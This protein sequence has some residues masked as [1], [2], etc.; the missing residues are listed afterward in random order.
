MEP[1]IQYLLFQSSVSLNPEPVMK[2]E[3][4]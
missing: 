2:D 3:N 1:N 4:S